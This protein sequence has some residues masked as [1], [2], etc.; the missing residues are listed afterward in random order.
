VARLSRDLALNQNPVHQHHPLLF[1]LSPANN[2][3]RRR[4]RRTSAP[5]RLQP[6]KTAEVSTTIILHAVVRLLA[7]VRTGHRRLGHRF[8]SPIVL[9]VVRRVQTP[10]RSGDLTALAI[11]EPGFLAEVDIRAIAAVDFAVGGIS[12]DAAAVR[13]FLLDRNSMGR[14]HPDSVPLCHSDPWALLFL[15]ARHP[16]EVLAAAC[17]IEAVVGEV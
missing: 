1:L 2:S 14:L 3:L 11:Q 15:R 16:F 13:L 5:P 8:S 7:R 4:R 6:R 9:M 10:F 12:E 17:T